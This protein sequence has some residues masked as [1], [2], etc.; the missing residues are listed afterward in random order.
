MTAV[1]A[2]S[3]E[4]IIPDALQVASRAAHTEPPVPDLAWLKRHNLAV[5]RYTS[6]PPA[7][8]FRQ[9]VAE[10]DLREWIRESNRSGPENI[11]LYFHI[12]FCPRRC[13]FCGCHTEI[14][15]AGSAIQGYL[16]YL[17]RETEMMADLL[18]AKRPLTQIHF[19]GGTPNA[20]PLSAIESLLEP[21]RERFRWSQDAE[22]AMECDP[23]LISPRTIPALA[24]LGFNRLSFGL[25]DFNPKV[26]EAVNRRFPRIP[27]KELFRQAREEGFRGN[28]LD[29]IY[30]LPYQT[31]ETFRRT[32]AS[33]IDAKPDRISLFPYA[34]VPWVKGHQSA[35]ESHPMPDADERLAISWEARIA[36]ESA[37][38]VAVGMDHFALRGDALAD[39]VETGNLHRN[40]QGY[41]VKSLAGQV[42]ALGA[43]AITQLESGYIQN[44]K[45]LAEYEQAV[46]DGRFPWEGAY[47]MRP[48]DQAVREIIA[49]LL[50]EGRADLFASLE[51]HVPD[52]EW[53][54]SYLEE[55]EVRLG[56]LESEGLLI[57]EKAAS[58]VGHPAKVF[59]TGNGRLVARTIAAALDP[60]LWYRGNEN[61]GP[62]YSRAV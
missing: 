41:T 33:A 8:H 14:G 50:C 24:A 36:L 45:D 46:H 59:L 23:N 5:P 12:P 62:R 54:T 18:D 61:E 58:D 55:A 27:P 43:S 15:H 51:H 3:P 17:L 25:Q 7:P 44:R 40:F 1:R 60:M 28:N 4:P 26:L 16:E 56:A 38:Y 21:I 52:R 48:A 11:S 37:G 39:A 9:E 47:R 53:K 42:Y 19:G 31:R 49:G 57:T 34:H 29:L 20:V 6:Y 32:V 35:L 10:S 2:N 22:V 30:G 13:L